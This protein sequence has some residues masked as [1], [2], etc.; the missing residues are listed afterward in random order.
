MP[1]LTVERKGYRRKAYL[2]KDGTRVEAAAVGPSTFKVEDK[3]KPGRTPKGKRWFEPGVH[4]GWEKGQPESERRVKVLNAHKGDELASARSM[5]ALANVTTD[6]ET[7]MLAK[8]DA[9]YFY[10]LHREMPRRHISHKKTPRITP[11]RPALKRQ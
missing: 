7:K 5:M 10:R 3:G 2:R 11:K 4:T 1:K 9:K 6:K 8:W